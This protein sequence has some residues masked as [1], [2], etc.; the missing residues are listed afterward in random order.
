MLQVNLLGSFAITVNGQRVHSDLGPSGQRMAAF[1]FAFPGRLHRRERIADLFWPEMN[2]E[3][4]RAALNS[5]LWRLRKI[6]GQE[7][8]SNGGRNLRSIGDDVVLDQESWLHVDS[9]AVTALAKK[10]AAGSDPRETP[11]LAAIR[12]AIEL[13]QGPFLDGEENSLFLEERERV[14]TC[15]VT[16]AHNALARYVAQ[17]DYADA[18]AVC[19]TVLS[20]DPF[21]EFFVRNILGLLCLDE[22]RAEAA[23]FFDRWQKVLRTEIGVGPM[24]ETARLFQLVRECDNYDDIESIRRALCLEKAGALTSH[25]L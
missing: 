23:R 2:T 10:L 18:I 14:H 21:R 24:P 4:S 8:E 11:S 20:F 9:S 25:A 19:R 17:K 5:A 3:R 22:Q 7:P 12:A 16:L 13:Y 15:F 6:L 1:L